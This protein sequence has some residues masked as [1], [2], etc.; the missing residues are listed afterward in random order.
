MCHH[1][2]IE[3]VK[4]RMLSRRELFRGTLAATAAAAAGSFMAGPPA[5]AAETGGPVDMTHELHEDFP[6]F[7]GEQQFFR[8]QK[9]NWDEHKFNLLEL[10]VN[11][12]TGTHMDAPLHFS[13]DGQSVAEVP[14]ESLVAPLAV[15][16]IREK[17]AEN[18]DA[19]VT[20][21]DIKAWTDANGPLPQGCCVATN[22]GW[23]A[24]ADGEAFRNV[25]P[26]DKMHFPGF[27][28]EAAKMLL[29]EA[30][31]V[32]IAVDTLSLDHGPSEDFATHYAWLPTGRWGLEG[33]AN[34]SQLPA[35]GATVV[36]G[37]P[38]HR[39]GT[40]GPSRVLALM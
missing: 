24:R 28:V 3:S 7:F 27:H 31:V 8:E 39:G 25:G 19:Q 1:C 22:S 29:E 37:A 36:V 14:V 16:D 34:L 9:F 10:R 23:D 38:K 18:P 11:E 12:H 21:D 40:G 17:A 15:I 6:T 35:T 13:K 26:D 2:V 33:V 20:P 5:R 4:Q 30:G 32:G